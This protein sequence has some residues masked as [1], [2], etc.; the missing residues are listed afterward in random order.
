MFIAIKDV[1]KNFI[2]TASFRILRLERNI[3]WLTEQHSSML[4][5]VWSIKIFHLTFC[6]KLS[7]FQL[8]NEIESL[9]CRN[10][11]DKKRLVQN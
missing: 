11:G 10:R 7:N 8:H 6:F 5:Q 4:A 2:Q 1:A 3:A 9:K